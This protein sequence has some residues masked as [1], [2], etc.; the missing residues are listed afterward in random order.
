VKAVADYI[1]ET[2]AGSGAV[3][4]FC[5]LLLIASGKYAQFLAEFQLERAQTHNAKVNAI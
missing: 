4:E 3:R 2:A 1:T 5:D